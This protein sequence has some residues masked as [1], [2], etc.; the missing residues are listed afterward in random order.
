MAAGM[1]VVAVSRPAQP[2]G[3][4][5]VMRFL[6]RNADRVVIASLFLLIATTTAVA[7]VVSVATAGGM[8]TGVC[9]QRVHPFSGYA[10]LTMH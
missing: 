7:L 8:E 10:F 2:F 5:E 3:L 6:R 9:V 4:A 1:A